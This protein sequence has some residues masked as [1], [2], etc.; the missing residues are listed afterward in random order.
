MSEVEAR[1]KRRNE[2]RCIPWIWSTQASCLSTASSAVGNTSLC[3]HNCE[4]SASCACPVPTALFVSS[5]SHVPSL[6]R[7]IL[8]LWWSTR[9][10][11]THLHTWVHCLTSSFWWGMFLMVTIVL[12]YK[13]LFSEQSLDDYVP[14]FKNNQGT[15]RSW[16]LN[17]CL[18]N[19]Q[20][21]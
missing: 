21:I 16:T 15:D 13:L 10:T 8:L 11:W 5:D 4:I 18:V 6:L 14:F 3:L 12:L 19:V 9:T 20:Y 17:Y 1:I 2:I 7:P